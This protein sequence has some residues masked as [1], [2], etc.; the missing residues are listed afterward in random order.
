MRT[1]TSWR[2]QERL[3]KALGGP[4]DRGARVPVPECL[5]LPPVTD[6]EPG[7]LFVGLFP[8]GVAFADRKRERHGD[9][10][11]LA[12][13]PYRTCVLEWEPGV[14][15]PAELRG[16]I[17]AHAAKYKPG[18]VLQVSTAGQTVILGDQP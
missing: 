8:C 1:R 10:L 3:W 2:N 16:Q 9:Y 18:E 17:M 13:L 12:F 14:W 15:V 6:P 7:R 4:F 11:K 5:G